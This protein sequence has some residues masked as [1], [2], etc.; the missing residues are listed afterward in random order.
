MQ[1]ITPQTS[2]VFGHK[3]K[4]SSGQRIR[5]PEHKN[6]ER[7]LVLPAIQLM[8]NQLSANLDPASKNLV[9]LVAALFSA[10]AKRLPTSVASTASFNLSIMR[11][12][13]LKTINLK[14]VAEKRARNDICAPFLN[15]PGLTFI[16]DNA[17]TQISVY[18][19]R[20]VTY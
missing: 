5:K 4:L 14:R 20:S 16:P 13:F 1:T 10:D 15:M 7:C 19:Y 2:A 18:P 3:G 12:C 11:L 9:T 8:E 17:G 6:E